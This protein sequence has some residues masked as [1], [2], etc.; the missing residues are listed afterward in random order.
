MKKDIVGTTFRQPIALVATAL[1]VAVSL[2]ATAQSISLGRL[3]TGAAITFTHTASDGWGIEIAGGPAPRI[4]QPKPAAIEVYRADDDIR[5]LSTGYK[6]VRRTATGIDATA[7]ISSADG[8]I[9]QIHDVWSLSGGVLSVR[10]QVKVKGNAP[11]GFGSSIDF[12]LDRAVGWLDVNFMS[13]GAI[14][15]DPTYDG[16]RSPGGTLTYAARRLVMREDI[17]AAPLFA[18]SFQNGAS[19][20]MLDPHPRGDSIEEE[21]KLTKLVMT[22]ARIQFG[23]MG[24][25]QAEDS[26]VHLG[27]HYPSTS[28]DFGGGRPAGAQPVTADTKASTTPVIPSPPP[29]RRRCAGFAATTPSTTALPTVTRSASASARMSPSAT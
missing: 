21:T 29:Y 9:F 26:A 28:T 22:D 15:A 17:L 8:V 27:F 12:S 2:P 5:D 16:D 14:Y 7:D 23:A 19:M 13:P 24:A 20:A 4:A 11:G 6:T 1:F 25:W 10:R 18:I 3:Q